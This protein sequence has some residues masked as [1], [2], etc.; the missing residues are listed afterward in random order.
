[1]AAGQRLPRVVF[2]NCANNSPHPSI[3]D[4]VPNFEKNL[5]LILEMKNGLAHINFYPDFRMEQSKWPL[6]KD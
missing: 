1:M 4:I 3:S 5:G 6:V 2:K